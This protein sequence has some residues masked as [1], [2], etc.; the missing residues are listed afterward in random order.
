MK[1]GPRPLNLKPM[2]EPPGDFPQ[3][4]RDIPMLVIEQLIPA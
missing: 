3:P 4:F 2:I 1:I